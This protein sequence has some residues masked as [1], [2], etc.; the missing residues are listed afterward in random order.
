MWREIGPRTVAPRGIIRGTDTHPSR[1][2]PGEVHAGEGD[3]KRNALTR[4]DAF[5]LIVADTGR[6][7]HVH[8]DGYDGFE[9]GL[10]RS[11]NTCMGY[12]SNSV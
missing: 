10:N 4:F 8:T 11:V 1:A 12:R 7:S 9:L 5:V 3:S 6:P 2:L